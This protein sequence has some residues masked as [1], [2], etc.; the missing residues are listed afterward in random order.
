MPAY[1]PNRHMVSFGNILL[2]GAGMGKDE[3]IN[4]ARESA[5]WEDDV[6]VDGEVTF[7]KINDNR[8]TVTLTLMQTSQLNDALSAHYNADRATPGGIGTRTFNMTDLNGTTKIF[9]EQSRLT[10]SPDQVRA[11]KAGET[12]WEFRLANVKE[13]HGGNI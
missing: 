6:G 5:A 3:W 11:R 1:D 12:K 13:F 8:M 10:K 4:A 2:Y 7:S 9:A